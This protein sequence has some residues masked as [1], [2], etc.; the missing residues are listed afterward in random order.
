MT[1][2][3]RRAIGLGL[4][5]IIPAFL[6]LRV[7]PKAQAWVD[8]R[9]ERIH[10]LEQSV[11]RARS[12]L[13]MQGLAEDSLRARAARLV[14]WAPRLF[15]SERP[16]EFPAE[17][18]SYLTGQAELAGLRLVQQRAAYDSA[19]TMFRRAAVRLEAEG[20]ISGIAGWLSRLEYG[21]KLLRVTEL[22]LSAP[23]PGAAP[24]TAEKLRIEVV[25][26]GWAPAVMESN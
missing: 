11:L 9:E 1:S 5:V 12:A 21:P 10:Q 14:G 22:S 18:A 17:L 16:E 4:A 15:G 19:G 20:D 6:G 3:D 23:E 13:A 24:A 26:T 25:V 7:T 8:A 2:R